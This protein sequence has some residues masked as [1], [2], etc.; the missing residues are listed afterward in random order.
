MA[1]PVSTIYKIV[2]LMILFLVVALIVWSMIFSVHEYRT[3][4]LLL[5]GIIKAKSPLLGGALE[6]FVRSFIW[7]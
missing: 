6:Y 5:V 4:A 2:G 7:F 3:A 1:A